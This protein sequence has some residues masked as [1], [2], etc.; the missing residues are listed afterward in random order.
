MLWL[1]EEV[2]ND[3]QPQIYA[4]GRRATRLRE[5]HWVN[6]VKKSRVFFSSLLLLAGSIQRSDRLHEFTIEADA[7]N[8][9]K[10]ISG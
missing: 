1:S 10:D 2:I 4:G 9:N 5:H 7:P 8:D 3:K 6:N